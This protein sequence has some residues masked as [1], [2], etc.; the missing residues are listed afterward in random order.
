MDCD[1]VAEL[2]ERIARLERTNRI[3]KTVGFLGLASIAVILFAGAVE[4]LDH[5]EIICRDVNGMARASIGV[6]RK[7]NGEMSWA[8]FYDPNGS[9]RISLRTRR[10][11]SSL[12]ILDEKAAQP[13]IEMGVNENNETYFFV[14]DGKGNQ[15]NLANFGN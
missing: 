6:S 9:I 10:S 7:G 13:R 11:Q 2:G 1:A 14:R 3:W 12:E 15:K 5:G 8:S 4:S